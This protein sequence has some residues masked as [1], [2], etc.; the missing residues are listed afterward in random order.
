[1]T[2][3]A[4]AYSETWYPR[5]HFG[6]SS[7]Q[8][9][10]T[11]QTKYIF[12]PRDELY[13]LHGDPGEERNLAGARPRQRS[14]LRGRGLAFISRHEKGALTPGN[15]PSMSMEDKRR[16]AALGYLSGSSAVPAPTGPL[17]DPKDKLPDYIAF[18][19]AVSQLAD[20][21]WDEALASAQGIV[22]RNPEFADAVNLLGNA[23]YGR[24]RFPEA[25]RAFRRAL[26]LKPE[27]PFFRLD[28]LK[29]LQ[30]LGQF[31]AAAAETERFLRAAPE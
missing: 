10:I 9:F 28:L 27:D 24:Q 29:T 23:H 26:T 12:A 20:G 17:A 13:D 8:A 5:L 11:G 2:G 1:M 15:L 6:W 14:D 7:L 25:L 21:R 22:E 30:A 3:S 31:D 4:S 16:L 18:G 19:K